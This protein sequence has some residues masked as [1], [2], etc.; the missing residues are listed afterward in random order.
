VNAADLVIEDFAL[1]NV[2]L[3][4]RA[5]LAEGYRAEAI[6][7]IEKIGLLMHELEQARRAN[8]HLRQQLQVA[9]GEVAA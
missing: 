3:R 2:R 8:A 9:R 4:E 7:A 5:E 6:E 1:E